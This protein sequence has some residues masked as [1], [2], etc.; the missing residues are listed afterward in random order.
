MKKTWF[1]IGLLVIS[2]LAVALFVGCDQATGSNTSVTAT[3][4]G[5]TTSTNAVINEILAEVNVSVPSGYTEYSYSY[6]YDYG[7]YEYDVSVFLSSDNSECILVYYDGSNSEV[8]FKEVFKGTLTAVSSNIPDVY[9]WNETD[10]LSDYEK[11]MY[12]RKCLEYHYW[13]RT[14]TDDTWLSE[15]LSDDYVFMNKVGDTLAYS[16]IY[17]DYEEEAFMVLFDTQESFDSYMTT[18]S[19]IKQ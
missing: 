13:G 16:L 19:Y 15:I 6:S 4:S 17:Y 8:S 10:M 14:W 5:T 3:T 12:E 2:M 11:Y 9:L 1:K 7:S 18:G